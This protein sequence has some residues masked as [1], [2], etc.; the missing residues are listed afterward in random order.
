M[1]KIKYFLFFVFLGLEI[2]IWPAGIWLMTVPEYDV[3]KV[4]NAMATCIFIFGVPL[5]YFG[6]K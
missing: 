5:I 6:P 2:A 3:A 4:G 1:A